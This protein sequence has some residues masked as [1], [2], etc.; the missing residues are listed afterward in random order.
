MGIVDAS[1]LGSGIVLGVVIA[2]VPFADRL[3]GTA[4]LALR[5]A[6]IALGVVLLMLVMGATTTVNGLLGTAYYSFN[7]SEQEIAEATVDFSRRAAVAG[8]IHGGVGIIF[9]VVGAALSRTWRALAPGILLGGVLLVLVSGPVGSA[10][11]LNILF[12]A[13]L[14][15]AARDPGDVLNIVR[16]IVLAVGAVVLAGTIYLLWERDSGDEAAEAAHSE[17]SSR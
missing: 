16:L 15:G 3:G 11:Q 12:F 2:A 10:E 4:I 14:P 6:Q 17:A 7:A 9:L 1:A 8:T 13:Q 5:S